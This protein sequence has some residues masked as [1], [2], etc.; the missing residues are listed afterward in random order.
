MEFT[1][2]HSPEYIKTDW[3]DYEGQ[4]E[5]LFKELSKRNIYNPSKKDK[6]MDDVEPFVTGSVADT[7]ANWLPKAPAPTPYNKGAVISVN[8]SSSTVNWLPPAPTP[9]STSSV[10]ANTTPSPPFY[11]ADNIQNVVSNIGIIQNIQDQHI[12]TIQ[13]I[14]DQYTDLSQ[15]VG[16]TIDRMGYLYNNNDKYHYWGNDDPNVLLR[17]EESKDIRTALQSDI[18]EMKLYQNSMY[19]T[20]AIACATLLIA[21]IIISK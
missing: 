9:I 4:P 17:P 13:E 5:V 2:F 19:V 3:K 7:T 11:T 14:L 20:T 21:A 10:V 8:G 16:T 12:N 1:G 6:Q 18:I 15:N